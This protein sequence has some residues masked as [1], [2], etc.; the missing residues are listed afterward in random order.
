MKARAVCVGFVVLVAALAAGCGA[1][2]VA[3]DTTDVPS[4]I[5]LTGA[6][7]GALVR[8]GGLGRIDLAWVTRPGATFSATDLTFVGAVEV[9]PNRRAGTLRATLGGT[10]TSPTVSFRLDVAGACAVSGA[11][12][13]STIASATSLAASVSVSYSGCPDLL[14][15]LLNASEVDQVTLTKLFQ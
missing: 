5:I 7:S 9:G 8:P 13:A 2:G 3:P 4:G 15:G 14:N 6:W 11:T 10:S 12:V 1:D